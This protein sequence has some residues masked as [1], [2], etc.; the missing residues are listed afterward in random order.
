[1]VQIFLDDN[2]KKSDLDLRHIL[3][4]TIENRNL[5]EVIEE[6]SSSE[7][8]EVIIE[9]SSDNDISRAVKDCLIYLGFNDYKM[10]Y[11]TSNQDD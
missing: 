4:D 8:L 6:T 3:V 1:M 11:I 7:E 5:G 10:E 2:L 9:H